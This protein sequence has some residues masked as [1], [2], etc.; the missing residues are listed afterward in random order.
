M[1]HRKTK[2][3]S[4]TGGEDYRAAYWFASSL[5]FACGSTQPTRTVC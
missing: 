4:G 5:G 2:L 3:G 1:F